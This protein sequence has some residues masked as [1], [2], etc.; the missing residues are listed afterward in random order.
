MADAFELGM[1][2]WRLALAANPAHTI[3]LP[4]LWTYGTRRGLTLIDRSLYRY[5]ALSLRPCWRSQHFMHRSL[6]FLG[7]PSVRPLIP[8]LDAQ[9]ASLS[10][11]RDEGL[12]RKPSLKRDSTH[13]ADAAA[14]TPPVHPG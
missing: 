7:K 5:R 4:W 10:L 11:V 3:V 2:P 1:D 13:T 9:H 14:K 12:C 6:E 8:A